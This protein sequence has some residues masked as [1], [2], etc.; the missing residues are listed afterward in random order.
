MPPRRCSLTRTRKRRSYRSSLF[1]LR[2]AQLTL[3]PFLGRWE[4]SEARDR[5]TE[6][7]RFPVG[8]E[9]RHLQ[10]LEPGKEVVGEA[11]DAPVAVGANRPVV[12]YQHGWHRNGRDALARLDQ[13]RI[14]G[15]FKSRW[16][17]IIL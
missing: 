17:I 1:R 3:Q 13:C 8:V 11:G 2:L 5:R 16:Q 4:A 12:G 9:A 14:I 10:L 6:I 15:C 7:D